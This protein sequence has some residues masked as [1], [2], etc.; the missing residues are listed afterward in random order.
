MMEKVEE[1]I[2]SSQIQYLVDVNTLLSY[3]LH[4]TIDLE[5]VDTLYISYTFQE[6]NIF[7]LHSNTYVVFFFFK[8]PQVDN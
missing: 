8:Y 2:K 3:I 5:M 1:P 6:N 4:C 7:N